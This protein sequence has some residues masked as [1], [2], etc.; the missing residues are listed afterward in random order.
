MLKETVSAFPSVRNAILALNSAS[1]DASGEIGGGPTAVAAARNENSEKILA[2]LKG[3]FD[4]L[5]ESG[6]YK[7]I[8]EKNDTVY[9]AAKKAEIYTETSTP[10][11]YRF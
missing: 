9:G 11:K 10:P 4:R 3:A 7:K 8:L 2:A 5:I 6:D 1:L